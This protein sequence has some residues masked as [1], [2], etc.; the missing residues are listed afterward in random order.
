MWHRILFMVKRY[1]DQRLYGRV[2][3]PPKHCFGCGMAY[4]QGQSISPPYH[5][6]CVPK[7]AR[8]A[9]SAMLAL[10][11]LASATPVWA[12]GVIVKQS[13]CSVRWTA[14]QTNTDGS[15]LIDLS[16]Y[17]VYVASTQAGLAALT[18][19]TATVLS[20]TPN[21]ATGTTVSWSCKSLGL[22]Q[23]YV[24]V[25]AVDLVMN[26]SQRSAVL[27]FVQSDDLAPSVPTGLVVG[28]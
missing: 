3:V 9:V 4:V 10:G 7:S 14:P 17:G 8:L 27:P 15:E 6:A 23:W 25:D 1:C 26:R 20:A 12:E 19:P 28:P 11:L 5:A 16:G 22:G 2:Q 24:Q 21:P 13:Q 18:Q